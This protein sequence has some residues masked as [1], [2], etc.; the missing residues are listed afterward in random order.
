MVAN[1]RKMMRVFLASVIQGSQPGCLLCRTGG[2]LVRSGGIEA[3][4]P[5]F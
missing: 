5:S 1:D 4:T 2:V 3:R